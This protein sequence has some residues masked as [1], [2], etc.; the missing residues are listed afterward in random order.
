MRGP[1]QG[2]RV[3]TVQLDNPCAQE[4]ADQT[5]DLAVLDPLA[6]QA[7][8]DVVVDVVE[9]SR[10]VTFDDPFVGARLARVVVDLGDGVLSPTSGPGLEDTMVTK[11]LAAAVCVFLCLWAYLFPLGYAPYV[12]LGFAIGDFAGLFWFGVHHGRL[13]R[14]G[15]FRLND[16]FVT[17]LCFL[18]LM[19][20]FWDAPELTWNSDRYSYSIL[21]AAGAGMVSFLFRLTALTWKALR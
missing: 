11:V 1:G 3:S 12:L 20:I 7:H 9:A 13:E 6:H 2:I 16:F 19:G 5:Q 4:R 18:S 21:L 17:F 8:Q 15:D 14:E 10:D